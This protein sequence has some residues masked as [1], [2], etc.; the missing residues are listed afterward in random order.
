MNG[1]LPV[2]II[3]CRVFV[4]LIERH[5][6]PALQAEVIILEY[7]LHKVPKQLKTAMQETIDRIE[8]PS[9]IVLGYGLCGNGL[10]GVTAG[11]HT[12]L[13]ARADDCIAILLGSYEAY[14]REFDKT[15]GTYYL[16]KGWLEAGTDPLSEYE[17]LVERMGEQKAHWV[18]DQ[19]YQHYKRI[20]F[21]SHTPADLEAYRP[22]AKRVAEYCAQWGMHYEE[23]VGSDAYLRALMAAAS[24]EPYNE[25]EFLVIPPGG[26][27]TQE[28]FMR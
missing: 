18:M 13:I 4:D 8:Q 12:L 1:K 27:I 22:Q 11:K 5:L 15:P 3:A 23:I 2:V 21:V 16:T 9:L 24:G 7:G 19:Q 28:M 20:A 6:P 14:R 25:Q 26:S 10:R 17:S